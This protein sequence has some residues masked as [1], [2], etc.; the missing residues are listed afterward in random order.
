MAGAVARAGLEPSVACGER[1]WSDHASLERVVFGMNRARSRVFCFR[2]LF[3]KNRGLL[4]RRWLY[5]HV[6]AV[7]V[8]FVGDS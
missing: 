5:R 8:A 3:T 4:F 7:R 2:A 6:R 1:R